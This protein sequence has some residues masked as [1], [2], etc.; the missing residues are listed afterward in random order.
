VRR[1]VSVAWLSRELKTIA[2]ATPPPRPPPSSAFP[3]EQP[4]P[5][6]FAPEACHDVATRDAAALKDYLYLFFSP[7]AQDVVPRIPDLDGAGSVMALRDLPLE[8]PEG[9]AV[10]I[11]LYG[12]TAG[13]WLFRQPLGNG[14][15][16][17]SVF[18]GN[19]IL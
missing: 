1:G 10:V 4:L 3:P 2:P 5:L 15:K 18:S 14:T 13:P 7:F 6:A 8:V 9:E 12:K 17:T 11:D 16:I 19:M